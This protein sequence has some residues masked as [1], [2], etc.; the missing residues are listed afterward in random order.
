MVQSTRFRAACIEVCE[1]CLSN[2]FRV[3]H[4]MIYSI[5]QLLQYFIGEP[6]KKFFVPTW[7]D[8]PK[9]MIV[10]MPPSMNGD[11]IHLVGQ[12]GASSVVAEA[13]NVLSSVMNWIKSN[14]RSGNTKWMSLSHSLAF[15]SPTMTESRNVRVR[16]VLFEQKENYVF[17]EGCK[18]SLFVI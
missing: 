3:F 8:L 15:I 9:D 7:V 1:E 6:P 2:P 10:K 17:G 13:D 16:K 4:C 14:G 5:R 18:S 12:I 11:L